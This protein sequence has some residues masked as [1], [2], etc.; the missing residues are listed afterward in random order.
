MVPKWHTS[1]SFGPVDNGGVKNRTLRRTGAAK[2]LPPH[3]AE[4]KYSSVV[5]MLLYLTGDTRPDI[6]TAVHQVARFSHDPREKHSKAVLR[7][8]KYLRATSDKGMTFKPDKTV[9]VDCYVVA[10]FGLAILVGSCPLLWKS[11]LQTMITLSTTEAEYVA[12]AQS[13]RELLPLHQLIEEFKEKPKL[14]TPVTTTLHPTIFEDSNGCPALANAPVMS[15][16]TKYIAI[17]PTHPACLFGIDGISV[18]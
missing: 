17:G 3:S 9:K 12:F 13:I 1:F 14:K 5:W 10:D 16:R 4:W 8:A 7:I 2:D 11:E 6:T 18:Q 15:P